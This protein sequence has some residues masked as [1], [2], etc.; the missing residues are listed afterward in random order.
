MAGEHAGVG[1][2]SEFG[3]MIENRVAGLFHLANAGHPMVLALRQICI[4][5]LS[6]KM[7]GDK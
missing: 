5:R 2:S 4:Q 7:R 6:K 1:A 3:E